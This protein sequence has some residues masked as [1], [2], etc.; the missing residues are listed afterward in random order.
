LVEEVDVNNEESEEQVTDE[1]VDDKMKNYMSA[2]SR[3][4]K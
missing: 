2:I 1:E 3:T 4:L